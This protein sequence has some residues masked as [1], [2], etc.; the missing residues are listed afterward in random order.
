MNQG[1]RPGED[2]RGEH[3]RHRG[4]ASSGEGQLRLEAPHDVVGLECPLRHA[5]RIAQVLEVPVAPQLTGGDA[6]ESNS[7]RGSQRRLGPRAG[8]HI[9]QSDRGLDAPERLRHRQHGRGRAA[10]PA[11]RE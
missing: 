3:G 4:K 8:A 9:Q 2:S 11:A 1:L 7:L 6:L 10:R 5:E